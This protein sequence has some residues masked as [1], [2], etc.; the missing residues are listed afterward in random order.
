LRSQIALAPEL[1]GAEAQYQ[2]QY[3]R[4]GLDTLRQTLFG[5]GSTPRQESYTDYEEK[6][7]PTY[8]GGS[9]AS[10][11]SGVNYKAGSQWPGMVTGY[12]TQRTP[13]TKTRTVYDQ[14]PQGNGLLD[15]LGQVAERN[16][17][18]AT[19][20][21]QALVSDANLLAGQLPSVY[22]T[23]NPG[24]ASLLDL[25]INRAQQTFDKSMSPGE[26]RDV[27]QAIRSGQSD[28][29]MGYGPTD[30]WDEV[31]GVGLKSREL[32]QQNV[33]NA[34]NALTASQNFYGNPFS[35][36]FGKG[37]PGSEAISNATA[38]M[39]AGTLDATAPRLFNPESG[40]AGNIYGQNYSGA[41]QTNLTN[42]QLR[43]KY[44]QM[45]A[46]GGNSIIAAAAGMV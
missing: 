31:Y 26:L 17:A 23:A 18:E 16:R 44:A 36:L 1:Y 21:R 39:N 11:G 5:G 40:Y 34:T 9:S 27:Q 38:G 30:Q 6:Q 42:A 8:A 2:P 3:A 28:R 4:L 20:D 10:E 45:T 25:L 15:L 14:N 41:L 19:K 32:Q 35:V 12:Q 29:G 13:V 24:G 7:V 46:E 33:E 22:R 37:G 43:A